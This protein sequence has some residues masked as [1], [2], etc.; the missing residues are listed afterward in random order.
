MA[1]TIS[2]MSLFV[3]GLCIQ[4]LFLYSL[5]NVRKYTFSNKIEHDTNFSLVGS[6]Y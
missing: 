2:G 1:T 6:I 4:G 5:L 3:A